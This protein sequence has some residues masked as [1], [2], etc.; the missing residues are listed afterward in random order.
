MQTLQTNALGLTANPSAKRPGTGTVQTLRTN[1]LGLTANP[2]AK[3]PPRT[4]TVQTLQ[5]K[6]LLGHELCKPFSQ[7]SSWDMD[8]ANPSAKRPG[9]GTANPS[10]KRPPGTGTVQTSSQTSSWNR[11]CAN[12]SAKRPG[13]GTVRTLQTNV[14]LG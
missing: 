5:P 8:C 3:R 11:D 2:S 13:T 6:V 4:G 7:K 14:L 9:T 10:A 1:A 12:P